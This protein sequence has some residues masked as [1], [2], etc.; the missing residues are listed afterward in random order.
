MPFNQQDLAEVLRI[1][2]KHPADVDRGIPP[3]QATV[4]GPLF[5]PCSGSDIVHPLRMFPN[6]HEF[7]LVD[8]H[9]L[10]SEEANENFKLLE[11]L[12]ELGDGVSLQRGFNLIGES[13]FDYTDILLA[14]AYTGKSLNADLVRKELVGALLLLR[15]RKLCGMELLSLSEEVAGRVYK[16]VGNINGETKTIYYVSHF[17][18]DESEGYNWLIDQA[19]NFQTLFVKAF[20]PS[21]NGGILKPGAFDQIRRLISSPAVISEKSTMYRFNGDLPHLLNPELVLNTIKTKTGYGEDGYAFGYDNQLILA[22]ADAIYPAYPEHIAQK[23]AD[24][25]RLEAEQNRLEAEQERQRRLA[26]EE[27]KRELDAFLRSNDQDKFAYLIRKGYVSIEGDMLSVHINQ[28]EDFSDHMRKEFINAMFLVAKDRR[29]T[30]LR[31]VLPEP[32]YDTKHL[33]ITNQFVSYLSGAGSYIQVLA[34]QVLSDNEL[35]YLSDKALCTAMALREHG[36]N[37]TRIDVEVNDNG[38]KAFAETCKI[39]HKQGSLTAASIKPIKQWRADTHQVV[40]ASLR[41]IERLQAKKDA[42][43]KLAELMAEMGSTLF[44]GKPTVA[45]QEQW[46]FLQKLF[47]VF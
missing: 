15:L 9:A 45:R 25:D 1:V 18:G 35:N 14:I 26:I 40:S 27:S 11:E 5:Y 24:S 46:R 33:D 8:E 42:G 6:I 10:F 20:S 2:N 38:A 21:I 31:L 22:N 12:S 16:I 32:K 29:V 19:F 3:L 43:I 47:S 39:L 41:E 36:N 13:G 34:I 28:S 17:F 23:K 44:G 37:L 7:V 4:Q 30:K